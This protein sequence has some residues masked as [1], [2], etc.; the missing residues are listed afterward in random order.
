MYNISTARIVADWTKAKNKAKKRGSTKCKCC[1]LEWTQI[2]LSKLEPRQYKN[3]CSLICTKQLQK[4]AGGKAFTRLWKDRDKM[5]EQSS[6]AGRKSAAT[7]VRRSKDEI[8]LFELCKQ[9]FKNVLSNEVI[10]DGWDADIVIDDYKFAILWNGPWHYKQMPHK[11]HSLKQVQKRDEIK[12]SRL[13][14][15][16]YT[17]IVFEDRHYTPESAFESIKQSIAGLY[18]TTSVS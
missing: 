15:S 8:K 16:G 13:I 4:D 3:T 2:Y 11:N 14:A 5:I 9:Q 10:V 6:K 7:I 17:V 18:S 1:G 12:T